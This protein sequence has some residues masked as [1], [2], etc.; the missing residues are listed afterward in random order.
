[1]K[2]SEPPLHTVDSSIIFENPWLSLEQETVRDA[3]GK[4][5]PYLL[6]HGREY[7]IVVP[8]NTK[9]EVLL[10]R[11]YKHGVRR[12]V[13][14]F[15]AGYCEKN[16]SPL[17]AATRELEEETGFRGGDLSLL[18]CM[19]ENHTTSRSSY[20]IF[21]AENFDE[22][23]GRADN[24]DAD[25]AEIERLSVPLHDLC[26]KKILDDMPSASV[27]SAIPW[28]LEHKKYALMPASRN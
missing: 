9:G 13:L 17:D 5:R 1:M 10:L 21:I 4:T 6:T 24:P 16:E 23:E 12:H 7:V 8:V 22:G 11:Q 3:S 15:P 28:V 20:Y 26:S 19:T 14:T 2:H 27:M 18:A 25:E